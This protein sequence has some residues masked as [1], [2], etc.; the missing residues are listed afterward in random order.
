M[1]TTT[2]SN[3]NDAS[4]S[5]IYPT[6]RSVPFPYATP[7]SQQIDLMDALLEGLRPSE[8]T[9]GTKILIL[10]SPTGTG[11]SLSLACASLAWLRHQEQVD[12]VAAAT[13]TEVTTTSATGLDWLD[14]WTL[15]DPTTER[16]VKALVQAQQ[17]RN[18]LQSTLGT[19][20]LSLQYEDEEEDNDHNNNNNKE[21]EKDKNEKTK[22]ARR[23]ARRENLLRAA[24]TKAKMVAQRN[25]HKN[26]S[27]K[28]A[29]RPKNTPTAVAAATQDFCLPKYNS[30]N[31]HNSDSE[32]D[33][34]EQQDYNSNKQSSTSLLLN[35]TRLDGSAAGMSSSSSSSSMKRGRQQQQQQQH[36]NTNL[37]LPVPTVAQVTPG[38][39]VRK[40][41]YA[42]RTHSQLSQF[43]QEVKRTHWGKQV[44]VVALASRTSAGM[45]GHFA[46]SSM[47]EASVTEACLDMGKSKSKSSSKSASSTSNNKK[48]S[49]S[50]GGSSSTATQTSFSSCAC[51]WN[52]SNA[53]ETLALHLLTE[54]TSIEDAASLGKSSK[55]CAYYASRQAVAAA[56]LVVVPYSMLA[57]EQTRNAIGLELQNAIVLVDEAHN[58]PQAICGLH[59]ASL[60]LPVIQAALKQ[61]Q[62]YTAKYM[63]RL[64]GRNLHHL[65]V[66]RKICLAL[67]RHLTTVVG[68][69]EKEDVTTNK[70][71]KTL[72]SPSEFVIQL[73]LDS[74]NLYTL[75]RYM[76][77][78]RISQKLLG[79]FS[80]TTDA[81]TS[82]SP[83]QDDSNS[84]ETT[85]TTT[86]T[87][88]PAAALSKHVSPMSIVQTFLKKLNISTEQGKILTDRGDAPTPPTLRYVLLHP[89]ALCE[90][91]V[92]QPYALCLVGGTIRPFVHV[93]AELLLADSSSLNDSN[94]GNATIIQQAH[95]AD[96][97]LG[98]QP[99]TFRQGR[100]TAFTC[101]HVVPASNVLLQSLSSIGSINLDF[102]HGSRSTPRV[103][104]TLGLAILEICRRIPH[105]VVVFFPSYS[106]E[107]HLVKVW[108]TTDIWG[109]LETCKC[110]VREPKSSSQVQ[111]TLDKYSKAAANTGGALLLSV[112]GGKLS[113]GINF[114]NDLA[115][116]VV[117]V[118]LPYGDPTDPILKEKMALLDSQLASLQQQPR[119]GSGGNGSAATTAC[120]IS[121]RAYYQNLCMRA[122]NQSVGRAIRHANDYAAIIL[123]DGRYQSNSKVASG[124]PQWLTNST[125]NWQRATMQTM[126][127]E[128]DS[129]F[130][131]RE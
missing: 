123:L 66:L 41:I 87:T 72:V 15:P 118:G 21:E 34:D 121:G 92:T 65:G 88:T 14:A 64:C 16:A 9:N 59:T 63:Q 86:T 28:R 20:R 128:L 126:S 102:R 90:D 57:S 81:T 67:E 30:D 103:V 13:T 93:A 95:Q 35:G 36:S 25:K 77:H 116:G 27:S 11:K 5:S 42:A 58:L 22:M 1:P 43:V 49:L 130:D 79:F 104:Q 105:G 19:L 23:R 38:S 111:L 12:L 129:F 125:P 60:S 44:R 53:V 110:I 96:A 62:L 99:G 69:A 80:H 17:A 54:P 3:N 47:S 131:N 74:I 45:C 51:P 33:D 122:V 91:L 48:R 82:T 18:E 6:G 73:S 50:S 114:A 94:N 56:E 8:E 61:L 106:Y 119:T 68:V 83:G 46:K 29:R 108:K 76:E 98:N 24:I 10:E 85:T 37:L 7:Y 107:A 71:N 26:H 109:K 40:I 75:L 78:S 39:G 120:A 89:A 52:D 117:V 4:S 127:R 32:E 115:R 55:T 84:K 113:E 101:D 100:L 70:H 31:E 112:V 2:P 97:I 124:L